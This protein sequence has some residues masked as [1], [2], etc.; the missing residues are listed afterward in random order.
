M[1]K[2]QSKTLKKISLQEVADHQ[3]NGQLVQRMLPNSLSAQDAM[4]IRNL[5]NQFKSKA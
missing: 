1:E 3:T 2:V 5:R 4:K